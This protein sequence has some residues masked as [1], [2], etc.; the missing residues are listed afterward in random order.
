MFHKPATHPPPPPTTPLPLNPTFSQV[1]L[2]QTSIS[3]NMDPTHTH[4]HRV[5]GPFD[6]A[7]PSAKRAVLLLPAYKV[8]LDS[9]HSASQSNYPALIRHKAPPFSRSKTA[10]TAICHRGDSGGTCPL[11]QGVRK[12]P[13]GD[14]Q[15]QTGPASPLWAV[16]SFLMPPM[17][18]TIP[19]LSRQ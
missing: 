3:K 8:Q 19:F 14:A 7:K 16:A 2:R 1:E 5:K 13:E 12:L 9:N 17:F 4:T 6:V 10:V 11:G 15:S 18:P